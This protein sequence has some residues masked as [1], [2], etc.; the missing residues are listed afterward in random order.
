MDYLNIYFKES[1]CRAFPNFTHFNIHN[2][3]TCTKG[4]ENFYYR[5]KLKTDGL[6]QTE[7]IKKQDELYI[8]YARL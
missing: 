4:T 6:I 2:S 1:K 3:Y 8:M 5:Q 7:R